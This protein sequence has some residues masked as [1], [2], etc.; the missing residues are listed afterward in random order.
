[1]NRQK[2]DI[3]NQLRFDSR[4]LETR[5]WKVSL[6]RD[7]LADK[8]LALRR[9]LKRMKKG[10][11]YRQT[12]TERLEAE[13]GEAVEMERVY[14]ETLV[15]ATQRVKD[16]IRDLRPAETEAETSIATQMPHFMQLQ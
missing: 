13:L 3:R 6:E 11:A 16:L 5:G 15:A 10:A 1:L 9:K 14:T 4:E 8:L 7:L 12:K 2:N